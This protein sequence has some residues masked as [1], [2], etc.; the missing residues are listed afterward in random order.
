[1][2]LSQYEKINYDIRRMNRK[3]KSKLKGKTVSIKRGKKRATSEAISTLARTQF[4]I[5]VYLINT[6]THV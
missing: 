3:R 4:L 6:Y 1:M 2:L 5:N